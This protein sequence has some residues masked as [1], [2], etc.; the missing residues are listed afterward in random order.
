MQWQAQ[1]G[2]SENA[3]TEEIEIGSPVHRALDGFESIDVALR[4]SVAVRHFQSRQ[5]HRS[6][7]L[8]AAGKVR[9]FAQTTGATGVHPGIK[10]GGA[11]LANHGQELLR[12]GVRPL[13]L[14]ELKQP[15]APLLLRLIQFGLGT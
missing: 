9:Q 6:F 1:L 13:K 5:D 8:E 15:V 3:E 14:R 11:T 7:S 10:I 12:Q 2:S 4:D